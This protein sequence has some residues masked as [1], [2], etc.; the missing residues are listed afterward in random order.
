MTGSDSDRSKPEVTAP[1]RSDP[2]GS[3]PDGSDTDGSDTDATDTDATDTEGS[4]PEG[5]DLV[6][7]ASPA[8]LIAIALLVCV[9]AYSGYRLYWTDLMRLCCTAPQ[10]RFPADPPT[11]RPVDFALDLRSHTGTVAPRDF[12]RY[13]LQVGRD[14]VARFAYAPGYERNGPSWTATFRV[15]DAEIDSL[16]KEFQSS[17]LRHTPAPPEIP[18]DQRADG[19]GSQSMTVVAS[20]DTT[21]LDGERHDQWAQP[22]NQ[23]LRD[24]ASLTPDS[25]RT[26]MRAQHEAW[27]LRKFGP[28]RVP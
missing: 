12:S 18:P 5:I 14:Q 28:K 8:W 17:A 2:E 10:A 6:P 3:Y 23:F 7:R 15:T 1:G 11:E 19:G 16:W 13:R 27:A 21:A 4:D 25:I 9:A 22:V 24:V 26:R 20:R